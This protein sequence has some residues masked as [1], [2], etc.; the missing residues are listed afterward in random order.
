[1]AS[2]QKKFDLP[3][4]KKV[5]SK[6]PEDAVRQEKKVLEKVVPVDVTTPVL[7]SPPVEQIDGEPTDKP[8]VYEEVN[9]PP[10]EPE[11]LIFPHPGK[12]MRGNHWLFNRL[13][14]PFA[15]D[16]DGHPEE[17]EANEFRQ[18]PEAIAR[19][20]AYKSTFL[21]LAN[22]KEVRALVLEHKKEFGVAYAEGVTAQLVEMFDR[23]AD[24]NPSGR[25]TG[26][27]PTKPKIIYL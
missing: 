10:P 6:Y 11:K 14:E 20:L 4:H 21:F 7:A 19:F 27:V 15:A 18:Y 5:K 22:G 23:N 16:F 25:G 13:R 1:M 2:K 9:K 12:A 24:P 8:F 17:F 26:G 3:V